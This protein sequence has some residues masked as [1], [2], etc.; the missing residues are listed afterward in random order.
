MCS[1]PSHITKL[2]HN[3]GKFHRSRL[4]TG[5]VGGPS[6][7]ATKECGESVRL[8]Q[9]WCPVSENTIYSHINGVKDVGNINAIEMDGCRKSK[10][11]GTKVFHELERIAVK[12]MKRYVEFLQSIGK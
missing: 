9:K 5:L 7:K 1:Y 6:H 3:L 2:I 11:T 4:S 10:C 8:A 12:Y